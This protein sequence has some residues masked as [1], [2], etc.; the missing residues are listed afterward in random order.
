MAQPPFNMSPAPVSQDLLNQLI[1]MKTNSGWGP[2]VQSLNNSM[3]DTIS[4]VKKNDAPALINR[5]M[6]GSPSAP[7]Q[8]G[9]SLPIQ[10]GMGG[11]SGGGPMGG[12]VQPP[13]Q[14]GGGGGGMQ[15]PLGLFGGQQQGGGGGGG[16]GG[17]GNLAGLASLIG[18]LA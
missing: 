12:F 15:D 11:A 14:Q 16:G 4:N 6:G 10:N 5:F 1:Q 17:M 8:P 2:I 9:Q 13:Q 7:A 18:T 3:Q